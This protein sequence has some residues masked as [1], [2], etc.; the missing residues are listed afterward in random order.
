MPLQPTRVVSMTAFA[1]TALCRYAAS[2][3]LMGISLR[4]SLDGQSA[5]CLVPRAMFFEFLPV[6]SGEASAAQ[7]DSVEGGGIRGDTLLAH[8]LRHGEDYEL[9][10]T[11]LTGLCR[12]RIGD[13]VRVVGRH[14]GAPVVEFRFRRGTI[15]NLHGEKSTEMHLAEALRSVF[16]TQ[17]ESPSSASTIA[18]YATVEALP[19]HQLPHYRVY[20]EREKGSSPLK[21]ETTSQE[22]D[23]ALGE[24]NPVYGTWRRK[25]AIGPCEVV[26]VLPGAF[27]ELRAHRLSGGTSPQQLKPPRVLRVKAHDSFLQNRIR[28]VESREPKVEI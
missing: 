15:L 13:V 26:E 6:P 22:F 14:F 8:E 5:Y 25:G 9:V 24:A 7:A 3:G 12:Y 4:P 11:T 1:L 17:S 10:V 19:P 20:V 16:P 2:E 23:V 21:L 27:D 28:V 18:E